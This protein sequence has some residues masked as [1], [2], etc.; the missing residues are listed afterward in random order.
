MGISEKRTA[1]LVNF[2]DKLE[3]R[4]WRDGKALPRISWKAGLLSPGMTKRIQVSWEDLRFPMIDLLIAFTESFSKRCEAASHC[5]GYRRKCQ[6]SEIRMG[7][8]VSLA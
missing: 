6:V 7:M 8:V 1:W 5:K 3:A 4:G 2:V